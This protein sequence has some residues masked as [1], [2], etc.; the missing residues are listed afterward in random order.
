MIMVI[1][2]SL[3]PLFSLPSPLLKLHCLVSCQLEKLPHSGEGVRPSVR[4]PGPPAARPDSNDCK[5]L[6]VFVA[7][8]LLL[9]L[10][11]FVS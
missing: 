11:I 8:S 1:P 4:S 3:E 7:S 6:D 2:T 5:Q 9:P 10:S